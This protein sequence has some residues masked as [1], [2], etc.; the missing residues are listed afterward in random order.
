[1]NTNAETAIKAVTAKY[2]KGGQHDTNMINEYA[3]TQSLP[4]TVIWLLVV[5]VLVK[6]FALSALL[7]MSAAVEGRCDYIIGCVCLLL[8]TRRTL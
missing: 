6:P 4:W 8:T 5:T 2:C 1:M 7:P 3:V